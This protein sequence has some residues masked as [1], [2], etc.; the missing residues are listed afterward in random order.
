MKERRKPVLGRVVPGVTPTVQR[1]LRG[2]FVFVQFFSSSLAARLALL[3]FL[4]P[5]RRKVEPADAPILALA[6][7]TTMRCGGDRFTVWTWDN[8][9]PSVVLLHG[10]GSHAARF[11]DFVLELFCLRRGF[12]AAIGQRERKLKGGEPGAQRRNDR[13][14]GTV[15][16][17][18]SDAH[19]SILERRR[20]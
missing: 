10:W 15:P 16:P 4:K 7:R 6:K 5:P 9:G 1:R 19:G 2:F 3:M 14:E 12:G 20:G 11:A 18:E 13:L 8:P 17:R